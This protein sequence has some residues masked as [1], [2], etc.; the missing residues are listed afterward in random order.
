M[1]KTDLHNHLKTSRRW[2]E[3]DFNKAIEK[4]S[5]RL[6]PGA[7]IGLV[8]FSDADSKDDRYEC[9][10]GLPG[11]ERTPIGENQQ[12]IYVPEKDIYVLKA[13]E[14]PTKQGH[15]L[16]AGLRRNV[17]LK[18]DRTLE[19]SI[20][21]A[22]D[23]GGIIIADHP[24]HLQGIGNYLTRHLELLGELDAI[25]IHNGEA[26]FGFPVGPFPWNANGKARKFYEEIA[27]DFPDIGA[28]STSDGHSMYELGRSWTEVDVPYSSDNTNFV[29]NLRDAIRRTNLSTPR[30][31]ASPQG[32]MGAIDHIVDLVTIVKI[33]PIFGLKKHYWD[34]RKPE[35]I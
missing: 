5:R 18:V 3:G 8:N 29:D 11:Y 22:T 21:E 26:S 23:Q 14:V 16:V 35:K 10:I 32:V 20:A 9:F 31:E 15:L 17:Q 6:G 7:I 1:I 13:Q 24:F 2:S 19:D 25:E 28:L 33:A 27:K 12:G 34:N 4:A 30:H